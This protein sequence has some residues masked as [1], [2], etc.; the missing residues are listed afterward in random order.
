MMTF[1][2][3]GERPWI[4]RDQK[5]TGFLGTRV[6]MLLSNWHS[7]AKTCPAF[8]GGSAVFKGTVSFRAR[9][10]GHGLKFPLCE[11]KPPEPSVDK[12]GVESKDG[13]EILS[14]V[15]LSSPGGPECPY[16]A[17]YPWYRAPILSERASQVKRAQRRQKTAGGICLVPAEGGRRGAW[18]PVCAH[19]FGPPNSSSHSMT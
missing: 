19:D 17:D 11:F 6:G 2:L 8:T 16:G 10:I 3:D 4:H 9:I 14:T 1:D 5:G 12:I 18:L 13:H 7:V 15:Y